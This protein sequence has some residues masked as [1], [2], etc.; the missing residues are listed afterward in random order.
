MKRGF[1]LSI[2]LILMFVLTSCGDSIKPG[3]DKQVSNTDSIKIYFLS[4]KDN[5]TQKVVTLKDKNEIESIIASITDDKAEQFKCGYTGQMEFYEK[6][7]IILSPEF[8]SNPECAHY[9]FRYK[10]K[11]YHK[12]MGNEGQDLLLRAFN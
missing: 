11:M 9:V 8:N 6:G 4:Q 5:T 1:I 2:L 3:L 7:K 12:K 10:D